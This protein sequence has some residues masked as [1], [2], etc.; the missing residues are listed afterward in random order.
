MTPTPEPGTATRW[1]LHQAVR[2][3]RAGGVIA[4]PTEAVYGLGCDPLQGAAVQ[5]LLALKQRPADKGLILIASAWEQLQPFLLPLTSAQRQRL[6]RTWPG[7][8]TWTLPCRPEVPYWLR[9]THASLA[10]RITAHPVAA[11]LCAAW[12]GA[13]V[14]TSANRSGLPPARSAL[15]VRQQ[16][17]DELDYLLPGALGGLARPTAIRDGISGKTLRDA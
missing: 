3:L 9:G 1:H 17:G 16:F 4:Y 14:S 5:R 11:A 15:R 6:F 8:H 7:P 12:G 10:V 13:L 2:M